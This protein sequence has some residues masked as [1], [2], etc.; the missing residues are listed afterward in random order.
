LLTAIL[1]PFSLA[2]FLFIV[3]WFSFDL[4][5]PQKSGFLT[6]YQSSYTGWNFIFAP[7][8]ITL[9]GVLSWD[10]EE[11]AGAWKHRRLQPI[12]RWAHYIARLLGLGSLALL[13]NLIFLATV[14]AGGLILRSGVPQLQMGEV[15]PGLLIRIAGLSFAA[16]MPMLALCVWLPTRISG[17]GLNLLITAFGCIF[18]FRAAAVSILGMILPWGWASQVVGMVLEGQGS[19]PGAALGAAA[20]VVLFGIVGLLDSSMGDEPHGW[21]GA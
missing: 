17:I 14:L 11:E 20:S 4:V 9:S 3:F 10:L 16:C 2:C 18:A 5:K 13:A 1:T 21:R 19:I 7:I 15:Q 6:W 12:P 8:M